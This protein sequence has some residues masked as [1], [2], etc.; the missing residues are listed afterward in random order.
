MAAPDSTSDRANKAETAE[1]RGTQ[2]VAE[3][4]K[5]DAAPYRKSRV[6]FTITS[7]DEPVKLV[8]IWSNGKIVEIAE[9]D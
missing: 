1:S 2:I 4:L 7:E 6:R 8:A 3:Y 9:P 5:R